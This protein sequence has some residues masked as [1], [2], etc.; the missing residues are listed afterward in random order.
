[1]LI[2]N[3]FNLGEKVYV[4]TRQKGRNW[5]VP[6]STFTIILIE[7]STFGHL[8][9]KPKV[10]IFYKVPNPY[11]KIALYPELRIFRNYDDAINTCDV[12]NKK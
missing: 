9:S 7:I 2:E 10:Q 4:V 12:L 5:F 3:Q 8:S 1:M 11:S 6:E